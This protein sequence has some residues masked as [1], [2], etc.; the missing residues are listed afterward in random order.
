MTAK[1]IPGTAGYVTVQAAD[2]SIPDGDVSTGANTTV[3]SA[4]G[5]EADWMLLD[6]KVIVTGTPAAAGNTVDIFKRNTDQSTPAAPDYLQTYV[7]SAVIDAA[8]GNYYFRGVVNDDPADTYYCQNM[9]GGT[10]GLELQ[11]R[12]RSYVDN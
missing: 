11:A 12:L 4:F 10:V 5:A 6:F 7:G 8:A 9:T 2:A 3:T 1:H